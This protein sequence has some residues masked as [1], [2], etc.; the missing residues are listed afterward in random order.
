M[1][2]LVL[3]LLSPL[4]AMRM[5]SMAATK[6]SLQKNPLTSTSLLRATDLA[7][8]KTLICPTTT[9]PTCPWILSRLWLT[10]ATYNGIRLMALAYLLNQV[11]LLTAITSHNDVRLQRSVFGQ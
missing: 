5:A 10:R 7:C 11:C 9:C 4:Q 6:S 2:R 8:L 1:T 3:M